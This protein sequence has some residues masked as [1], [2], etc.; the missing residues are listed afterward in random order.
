MRNRSLTIMLSALAAIAALR[1]APVD[2]GCGCN[3]P[4]PPLALVRPAFAS[5]GDTVT[6]FPPDNKSGDFEIE[7]NGANKIRTK[8]VYKRDFADGKYKWQVV[9]KAPALPARSDGDLRKGARQRLQ[10][11]ELRLHDD[12]AGARAATG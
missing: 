3:K 11:G 9:V 8:A 1:S 12:A 4:P 7:F 2:A 5:P 6:F 10:R